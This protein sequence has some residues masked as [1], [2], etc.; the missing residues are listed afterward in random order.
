METAAANPLA[1]RLGAAHREICRQVQKHRVQVGQHHKRHREPQLDGHPHG[2]GLQDGQG[3]VVGAQAEI[4]RIGEGLSAGQFLGRGVDIGDVPAH[5]VP[6]AARHHQLHRQ[7]RRKQRPHAPQGPFAAGPRVRR[8]QPGAA[9]QKQRHARQ[10][11]RQQRQV[12]RQAQVLI[13]PGQ[14]RLPQ[15]QQPQH[16]NEHRARQSAPRSG[17]GKAVVFGPHAAARPF[18]I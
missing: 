2:D 12:A 15:R 7:H 3:R 13:V 18:L 10:R 6:G 1:Q 4:V 14:R 5:L 8:L 17:Q 16:K 9:P 11:H